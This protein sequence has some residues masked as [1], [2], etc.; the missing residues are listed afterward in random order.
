MRGSIKRLVAFGSIATVALLIMVGVAAA[1]TV[2][3]DFDL[4]DDGTV[5]LQD[6]WKSS[7]GYD[8]EVVTNTVVPATFGPSLCACRMAT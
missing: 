2:G 7:G 1:D 8:Q 6:G 4:F 5:N 3:T